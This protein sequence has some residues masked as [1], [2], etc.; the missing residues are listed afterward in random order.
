MNDTE[1]LNWVADRFTTVHGESPNVDFVQR[2]REV[3]IKQDS[4]AYLSI[5]STRFTE[6]VTL[7][8][9]GFIPEGGWWG[10]VK[11]AWRLYRGHELGRTVNIVGNVFKASLR[12]NYEEVVENNVEPT[13]G[14]TPS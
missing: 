8:I 4:I 9:R 7:N 1:F 2:L 13:T 3:A 10:R 11:A 6:P 5:T 14:A 12:I